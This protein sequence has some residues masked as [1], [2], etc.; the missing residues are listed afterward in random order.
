M[1]PLLARAVSPRGGQE[2]STNWKNSLGQ[3]VVNST[4]K[5]KLFG[6]GVAETQTELAGLQDR[7]QELEGVIGY[8]HAYASGEFHSHSAQ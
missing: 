1:E 7:T 8:A 2:N 6:N 3:G 4:N 5:I